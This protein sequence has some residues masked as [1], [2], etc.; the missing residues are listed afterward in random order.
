MKTTSYSIQVTD[1]NVIITFKKDG[2][3][4]SIFCDKKLSRTKNL[5]KFLENLREQV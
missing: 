4:C 2:Q 5:V 3:L 1:N